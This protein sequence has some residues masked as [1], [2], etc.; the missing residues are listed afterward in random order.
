M[1]GGAV[2]ESGA[3]GRSGVRC[4]G[5]ALPHSHFIQRLPREDGVV[6]EAGGHGIGAPN[7]HLHAERS[8]GWVGWGCRRLAPAATCSPRPG[9]SG[10]WCRMPNSSSCRLQEQSPRRRGTLFRSER[11]HGRP[12]GPA[13]PQGAGGCSAGCGAWRQGCLWSVLVSGPMPPS[14]LRGSP[15][16]ARQSGASR[17]ARSRCRS[18][19]RGRRAAKHSLPREQC[20]ELHVVGVVT[21]ASEQPAPGSGRLGPRARA[22][23]TCGGWLCG[24]LNACLRRQQDGRM[25]FG[26][27]SSS[28]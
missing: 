6:V 24:V 3:R 8:C 1:D 5:A 22:C 23:F 26:G 27:C 16:V 10:S 13:V 20:P 14:V 12:P 19:G 11:L 9:C 28:A 17:A 21:T 2:M 4:K 15:G 18:A 25:R 7:G